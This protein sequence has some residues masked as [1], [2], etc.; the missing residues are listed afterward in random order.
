MADTYLIAGLGNPGKDY[1]YTRHNI[2]FLVVRD[3]AE[4]LGLKFS[5]SSLTNGLTAE[6]MVDGK[7]VILLMPLTYM[8]RS[9]VAL[10]Q[11][12][13]KKD[14]APENILVVA[15]DFSL[16]FGQLRFRAKGSDGG[17]NGLGSVIEQLGDSDFARL[18]LGIG[19]PAHKSEVTDYVLGPFPK[20][21][22]K[23]LKGFIESATEGC[24]VWLNEGINKAMEKFNKRKK[25]G[26]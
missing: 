4:R 13:E 22:R 8:N 15:D 9:G 7:R 10:K 11:V 1:E 5:L 23:M 3:L 18:R 21:E 26:K 12:K 2:G 20:E 16:V 14:I 17:H 19:Q 25:D 24:L 6:G